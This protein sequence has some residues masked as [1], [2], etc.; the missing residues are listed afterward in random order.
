MAIF[1]LLSPILGIPF[2]LC[3]SNY[4]CCAENCATTRE[5]FNC[6]VVVLFFRD[7]SLSLF[8]YLENICPL[9]NAHVAFRSHLSTTVCLL[10]LKNVRESSWLFDREKKVR[11]QHFNM[12]CEHE[13]QHISE[14]PS[15][16]RFIWNLHERCD[17]CT[18]I[19]T[20]CAARPIL[21]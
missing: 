2:F 14:R 17:T 5:H 12:K 10:K 21:K 1:L 20:C 13:F 4:N 11:S 3:F 18:R 8:D 16:S 19:P 9:T 7:G 15:T 6:A